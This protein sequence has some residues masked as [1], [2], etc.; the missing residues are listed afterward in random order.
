MAVKG[1]DPDIVAAQAG[2][3]TR[4]SVSSGMPLVQPGD[5]VAKGQVLIRGE[6]RTQKGAM[7]QIQAQGQVLARTWAQGS[8]RVSLKQMQTVETGDIRTRIVLH[9]P[10]HTRVIRDAQP[11]A[12]QDVSVRVEPVVGLF[13]PVWREITT[14]AQTVVLHR[15]RNRGDA[16]SWAQG[17][18]EEIAKKQ[19]PFDALILDK[20]VDYSMI[21]NEFLYATVIL[22]YEMNIAGRIK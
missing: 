22:E 2:V 6:E 14:Y 15:A 5:V 17:A 16:A 12:S 8:A 21:D 11:F 19:C 9:S 4:I 10:W 18:A 20:T 13:L 3:I 7:R 1:N